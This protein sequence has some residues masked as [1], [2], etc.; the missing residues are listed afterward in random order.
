LRAHAKG[1]IE[2][3]ENKKREGV[4]TYQLKSKKELLGFRKIRLSLRE[5]HHC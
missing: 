5:S 3:K 1:K 2:L 4:V